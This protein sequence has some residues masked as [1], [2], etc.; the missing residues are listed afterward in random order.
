MGVRM[1]VGGSL[2]VEVVALE[3]IKVAARGGMTVGMEVSEGIK[4]EVEA[5]CGIRVKS[6]VESAI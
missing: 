2:A 4:V 5:V 1:A 6:A 3:G